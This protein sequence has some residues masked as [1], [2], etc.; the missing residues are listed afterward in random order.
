MT[1]STIKFAIL[2]A[3]FEFLERTISGINNVKGD[4]VVLY[5]YHDH[6]SDLLE[7]TLSHL[8]GF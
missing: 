6:L 2:L 1:I 3:E 8:P 7:M 5:L 4:I